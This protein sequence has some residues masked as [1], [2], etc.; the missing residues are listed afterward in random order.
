[1]CKLL[2]IYHKQTLCQKNYSTIA[3][4]MFNA[5]PAFNPAKTKNN[6]KLEVLTNRNQ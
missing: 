2:K 4:V 5:T 3:F 6:L 1:M